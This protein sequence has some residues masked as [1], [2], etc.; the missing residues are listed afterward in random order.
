MH[1]ITFIIISS[2]GGGSSSSIL[3]LLLLLLL[4]YNIGVPV[5]QLY[6][7]VLCKIKVKKDQKYHSEANNK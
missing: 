3:L 5:I 4:F 6:L 1:T 7:N 2:S